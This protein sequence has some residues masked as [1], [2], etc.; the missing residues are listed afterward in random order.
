MKGVMGAT[1]YKYTSDIECC[2]GVSF[3]VN[4]NGLEIFWSK[5]YPMKSESIYKLIS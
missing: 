3:G 2:P 5:V 4:L 1:C